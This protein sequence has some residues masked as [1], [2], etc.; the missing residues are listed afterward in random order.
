M[1]E[2]NIGKIEKERIR[3]KLSKIEMSR[4]LK[5][6]KQAYYDI[7]DNKSTK[8]STLKKIAKILD[9]QYKDLLT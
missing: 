6:S 8:L 7:L 4:R 5:M 9:F 2:I 1:N 3:L